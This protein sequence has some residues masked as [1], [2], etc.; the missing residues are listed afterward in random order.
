MSYEG[1]TEYLCKHGHLWVEN[2]YDDDKWYCP[3]CNEL[4][5][6]SHIV[7]QTNGVMHH[8]DGTPDLSTTH[9][10]LIVDHYEEKVIKV[11][12]YKVPKVDNGG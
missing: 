8:E 10:P 9:Y 6:W 7:D 1:Y 4:H 5:V 11:A 2:A 3:R 12:I